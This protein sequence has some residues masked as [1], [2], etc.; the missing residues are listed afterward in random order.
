ML[1]FLVVKGTV[2]ITNILL[3]IHQEDDTSKLVP[4]F[5]HFFFEDN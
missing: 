2:I 1:M 3:K 5:L 4:F